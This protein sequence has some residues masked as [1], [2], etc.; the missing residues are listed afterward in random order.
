MIIFCGYL[1]IFSRI[2]P[3]SAKLALKAKLKSTKEGA[4]AEV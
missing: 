1:F 2:F 3:V 4:S